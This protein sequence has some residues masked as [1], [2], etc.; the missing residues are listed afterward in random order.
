MHLTNQ[1]IR[2]AKA[3]EQTAAYAEIYA[4]EIQK[5][6][7]G[8]VIY[9]DSSTF[10]E[11]IK[12]LEKAEKIPTHQEVIQKTTIEGI[13][14]I[15]PNYQNKKIAVLD[16][17]EYKNPSR[18]FAEG[19][20]SQEAELC[21]NSVLYNILTA[22]KKDYYQVNQRKLNKSL[23][24]DSALYIPDVKFITKENDIPPLNIIAC[25]AP[26][27]RSYNSNYYSYKNPNQP[28]LYNIYRQRLCF[29][30][31]ICELNNIEVLIA[32][33]WG[34]GA[35]GN[36]SYTASGQWIQIFSF[37]STLKNIIYTIPSRLKYPDFDCHIRLN[38]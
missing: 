26:N 16:F 32:G 36:N 25:S 5:S 27:K 3:Q 29:I 35:D 22:F 7:D 19:R 24:T 34:T 9:R 12:P 14:E 10:R 23:Y 20:L 18:A 15:I 2:K 8:T 11:L 4:T 1:N 28:N 21:H 33:A 17:A 37:S 38:K 13:K 30:K 6:I 31:N